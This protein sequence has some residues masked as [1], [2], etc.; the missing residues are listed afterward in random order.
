MNNTTGDVNKNYTPKTNKTLVNNTG[1]G[2]SKSNT[3]SSNNL[4]L[5]N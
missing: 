4:S 3:L 5:Q 1:G 2:A